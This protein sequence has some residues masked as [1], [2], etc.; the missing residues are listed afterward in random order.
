MFQIL[1]VSEIA[2]YLQSCPGWDAVCREMEMGGVIHLENEPTMV[3]FC[4]C[5][6]FPPR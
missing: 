2:M 3:T 4:I 6:L 1:T 5:V